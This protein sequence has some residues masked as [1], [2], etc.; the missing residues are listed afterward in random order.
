MALRPSVSTGLPFEK[1]LPSLSQLLCQKIK[2]WISKKPIKH[3][4]FLNVLEKKKDTKISKL[5]LPHSFVRQ[6][7]DFSYMP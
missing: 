3:W 5:D 7:Q 1:Y 4:G 6:M 2:K